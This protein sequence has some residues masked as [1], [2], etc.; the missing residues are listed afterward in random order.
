MLRGVAHLSRAMLGLEPL[1]EARA[2][3]VE[4][5]ALGSLEELSIAIRKGDQATIRALVDSV[6][7][8]I[9]RVVVSMLGSGHADVDDAVQGSILTLLRRVEDCRDG[10]IER[11]AVGIAVHTTLNIIRREKTR[12]RLLSRLSKL[13]EGNEAPLAEGTDV[14]LRGLLAELVASLPPEQ[15]EALI[16]RSVL[17]YSLEEV[18]EQTGAP[19]NTV[20]SRI[21]LARQALARRI[22]ADP[23]LAD[24]AARATHSLH[25]GRADDD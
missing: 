13:R 9:Y 22:Q 14:V 24:L 6:A 11:F 18:A 21:R 10:T 12:F 25:A 4:G 1:G 2:R 17:E 5:A 23:R 15:A 20:R 3:D 7:P 8:S 19:V 16:R